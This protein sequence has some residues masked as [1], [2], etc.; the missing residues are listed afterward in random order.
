L[1]VETRQAT[2]VEA[3]AEV[4]RDR[5]SIPRAS[6]DIRLSS[7][8]WKTAKAACFPGFSFGDRPASPVSVCLPKSAVFAACGQRFGQT[9]S[10]D[11]PSVRVAAAAV[12][13]GD[14]G[15]WRPGRA[16]AR[17]CSG[18]SWRRTNAGPAPDAPSGMRRSCPRLLRT[19]AASYGSRRSG[20][21]VGREVGLLP[22]LAFQSILGFVK[23]CLAG[24]PA[25]RPRSG[26][27][28]SGAPDGSPPAASARRPRCG[29]GR[30]QFRGLPHKPAHKPRWT[31]RLC[32]R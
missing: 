17:G 18:Q 7:E 31:S 11:F 27:M 23:P 20:L 14:G 12:E 6:T 10:A 4:P 30:G 1:A 2:H 19:C 9:R 26:C 21:A 25:D 24:G 3:D 22:S 15:M 16:N 32:L 8:P 28:P 29:P 13:G 5:G